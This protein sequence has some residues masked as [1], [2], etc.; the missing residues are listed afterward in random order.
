MKLSTIILAIAFAAPSTLALAGPMNLADPVSSSL[1]NR[2]LGTTAR[3][4]GNQVGSRNTIVSIGWFMPVAI[5]QK[6][7]FRFVRGQG[8]FAF[9]GLYRHHPDAH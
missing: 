9:Q 5:K 3:P 8:F 4:R 7:A 2:R 1:R 6:P